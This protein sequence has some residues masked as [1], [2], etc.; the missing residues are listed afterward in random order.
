[1][2][3]SPRPASEHTRAANAGAR[4]ALPFED[5]R[6]FA[7]ARRG[8]VAALP[9]L[10]VRN[11]AGR[12]VWDMEAYRF[13][14]AETAPDTV[15]PSLWRQARLNTLHG[16]FEVAPGFYQV[17]GYDISNMTIVEGARG[18][19]VIDPLVS[20]ECAAA[21]LELYFAHRPRRPV[22]GLIY[23][24]SHVDHFGGAAGVVSQE[25][26]RAGRVPVLAPEGFLAHAVSE[27]AMLGNAMQRRAQYMYGALLPR[28]PRG[29]VD[30]GLGKT[31]STGQVS[32]IPPT[33]SITRTGETVTLDGVDMVF[34]L[35]PGTEA[36]AEMNF[37][38]PQH[39]LLCAAENT[40]HNMHNVLTLR[41][42]LVRDALAWS[43]YLH[44][45]LALF[46]DATDVLF[47]Q[48]HWP[49]WGRDAVREFVALQ[50]DLYRYLHDQTVRMLNQGLTGAE[51]AERFELPASLARAWH[52]RGYY[53][54]VSHNVKAVAQRYLGW[55]DGNPA[56]L[57][58]LP[59]EAAG[60]RYVELAGGADALLARARAAGEAGDYRWAAQLLDHLIF[61]EP[62]HA[63]ARALQA[64]VL[65]QL[66]YGSENATWRN[67]YL[68]GALELRQGVPRRAGVVPMTAGAL[69]L[70]QIFDLMGAR[71]NGPAAAAHTLVAAWDFS[72][73][74]ERWSIRVEHGALSARPGGDD[75]DTQVTIRLS[76]AT[77]DRILLRQTTLPEAVG[78]GDIV[79]EGDVGALVAV[80][81]SLEESTPDFPIVTP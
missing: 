13:L 22:T 56:R 69:S 55:F 77:L 62:D 7:D 63:A 68:Q 11:L 43:K 6:D 75:P 30:A 20:T 66:G 38:F 19:I 15:H 59:P 64:D 65:E 14:D 81:G 31:N 44:E 34:Q 41:G 73:L 57:H 60:R 27:N 42:A 21:A 47:A 67:F 26:V 2:A 28:G 40:S 52:C 18:V 46:G 39:R 71:L 37:H 50:R 61:A 74:G 49:T 76:R 51:V 4:A 29:Q 1:M 17:R 3:A 5:T 53:G 70:E 78:A 9:E 54:S 16:L 25:D 23:T 48:H 72:D 79:L 8:F 80:F 24:H 32:L 45:A 36:P 58:P 35:T 12:A 10:V 33:R